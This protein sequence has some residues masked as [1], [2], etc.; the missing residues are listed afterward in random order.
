MLTSLLATTA[1]APVVDERARWGL[2]ALSV[3]RR[4]FT[5][6]GTPGYADE[7]ENGEPGAPL[8][9]WGVGV[10][11]SAMN[12]A[13]RID[14]EWKRELA[15]FVEA[16]RSYWNPSGPTPGYDVLPMPKPVDRYYDDNAWMVLALVEASDVLGDPKVLQYAQ[17]ALKHS[18]SGEDATL[19][20]GVYWRESDKKSKNTCSNAPTVAAC[21][22]LYEKT[23]DDELIRSASRL[24]R[25]TQKNLQDPQD[26]LYWDSIDLKGAIDKTKWSYNSALMIRSGAVLAKL[27]GIAQYGLD[28]EQT[29]LASE[30][31]WLANGKFEDAGRFAH[32]LA[33]SFN[34][35]PNE[36][37]RKRV[38]AA[39]RWLFEHG[40][41]EGGLYGGRFDLPPSPYNKRF[42]LIDQASA[43]RAFL[44][45][46]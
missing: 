34:Y 16:T 43:A 33:E 2:E 8:F 11:M 40:R 35:V 22:A 42:E 41:D 4:E 3:I 30:N 7:I 45:C 36:A 25:W 38:D 32:L 39:L 23:M 24:Y 37:R 28:A 46:R 10:L 17:E 9:N 6:E 1:M 19:G 29:A 20:G 21:L 44:V 31:K 12:A 13:A 5:I 27:T 15:R 26:H 18:L 14:P